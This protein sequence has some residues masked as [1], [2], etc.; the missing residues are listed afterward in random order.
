VH[1]P[2]GTVPVQPGSV[3]GEEDRPFAAFADGQV[4]RPAVT[5]AKPVKVFGFGEIAGAHRAM[6]E[7]RATG[8]MAVAVS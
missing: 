4:D 3:S 7:H 8:K 6:E 2:P 5:R 1:D